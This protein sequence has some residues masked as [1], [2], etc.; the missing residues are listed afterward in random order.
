MEAVFSSSGD[1]TR[2]AS[3][4][5]LAHREL[6]SPS[7]A[8]RA[9]GGLFYTL[10]PATCR[11]CDSE[12]LEFSRLPVCAACLADIHPPR[13]VLCS[14]CGG[15][16][17]SALAVL[18]TNPVCGLCGRAHPPF[19]RAAAY[20]DYTGNLRDLIHLLK[21]EKV[22]PAARVLGG[23]LAEVIA[24]L[25]PEFGDAPVLVV[26]MPLHRAKSRQ[27]GFNQAEQIGKAALKTLQAGDALQLASR[28]LVRRRDTHS[29]IGLTRGQR[30][31]NMRGAFAVRDPRRL[32]GREVLLLDDVMTTGA[33][34]AECTRV[35][36]RAGARRVWVAT[37]ARTLKSSALLSFPDHRSGRE[38]ETETADDQVAAVVHH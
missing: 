34:A 28:L 37:V 2:T 7:W 33:T 17:D 3:A 14:R 25:R 1:R 4:E 29:Q 31:E 13:Q 38:T 24:R 19:E 5:V 9:L 32:A 22:L 15:V 26:P 21:Y 11:I 35:L 36:L 20:A 16:V 27:R 18:E 23:M 10:F 6:A 8:Q 30:R 12:L